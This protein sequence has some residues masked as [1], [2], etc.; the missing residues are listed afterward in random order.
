M[1]EQ[2]EL[3]YELERIRASHDLPAP[4]V[5]AVR[6]GNRCMFCAAVGLRRANR[7]GRVSCD[8]KFH[9]ASCTKSVTATLA[10]TIVS[11]GRLTWDTRL[12][13][14]VPALGAVMRPEYRA[15]TLE[16]LRHTQPGCL[17]MRS[18]AGVGWSNLRRFPA[19]T[20][21]NASPFWPKSWAQSLPAMGPV[22]LRT[23]TRAIRPHPPCWS[24]A[25][26]N[27]GRT[28]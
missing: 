1:N 23:P 19:R 5:A 7:S 16:R 6:G 25:P 14:V 9:I 2:P 15:A 13:D 26:A 8:D 10:A 11:E 17:P 3:V 21:G 27:H 4:A 24:A 12:A 22:R 18:S 28:S 20:Q